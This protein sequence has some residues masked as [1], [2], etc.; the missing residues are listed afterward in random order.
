LRISG[1]CTHPVEPRR[2]VVLRDLGPGGLLTHP[3][4]LVLQIGA[5]EALQSGDIVYIQAR[6]DVG[7]A[8][9]AR[10][11]MWQNIAWSI[12]YNSIGLGLAMTGRLHPLA[13]AFAML[14]S[15]LFVLWNSRR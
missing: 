10:R 14:G 13:A 1:S 8:R 9:T 7:I 3:V 6:R 2:K 15:S 5:I 4:H 11:R 12:G